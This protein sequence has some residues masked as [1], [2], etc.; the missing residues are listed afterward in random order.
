MSLFAFRAVP[1]LS[2]CRYLYFHVILIL[3][4]KQRTRYQMFWTQFTASGVEPKVISPV[5]RLN[6]TDKEHLSGTWLF[7]C[8]YQIGLRTSSTFAASFSFL[9]SFR[10]ESARAS[11]SRLIKDWL[12]KRLWSAD[13]EVRVLQLC[14]TQTH[15]T[16][17]VLQVVPIAL[18][19]LNSLGFWPFLPIR[20]QRFMW[21]R[22]NGWCTRKKV[23]K[24]NKNEF[25]MDC[26]PFVVQT[27]NKMQKSTDFFVFSGVCLNHSG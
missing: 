6:T 14:S 7:S 22:K 1:I 24:S 3:S 8:R 4:L 19:S 12:L 10:N 26:F 27:S 9:H 20:P 21:V 5:Q 18:D 13:E 23:S 15:K 25:T 11:I 2:Y 16:C 17:S